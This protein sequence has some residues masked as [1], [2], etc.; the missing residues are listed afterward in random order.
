MSRC[1]VGIK[2]VS[3]CNKETSDKIVIINYI[4]ITLSTSTEIAYAGRNR[5]SLNATIQLS[6]CSTIRS[7][8]DSMTRY[9]DCSKEHVRLFVSTDV[10]TKSSNVTPVDDYR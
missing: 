4:K 10:I 5:R 6:N 9:N 8:F 2:R 1:E 3:L 7:L